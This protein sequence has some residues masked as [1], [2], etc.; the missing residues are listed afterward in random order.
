MR[1][2]LWKPGLFIIN[3]AENKSGVHPYTT[4]T[5]ECDSIVHEQLTDSC[6]HH[7]YSTYVPALTLTALNPLISSFQMEGFRR[8]EVTRDMKWRRI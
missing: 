6:K 3:R 7:T 2:T 8:I 1:V 5:E 4:C